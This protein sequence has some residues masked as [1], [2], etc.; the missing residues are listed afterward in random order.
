MNH[1]ETPLCERIPRAHRIEERG[2]IPEFLAKKAAEQSGQTPAGYRLALARLLKF[3]GA[4]ATVGDSQRHWA[5]AT[6]PTSG[7]RG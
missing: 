4:E 7:P 5:I 2:P 1:D 3:A 6:W